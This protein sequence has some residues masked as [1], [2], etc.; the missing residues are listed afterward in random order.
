MLPALPAPPDRG[1]PALSAATGGR[2]GP[3]ADKAAGEPVSR[4]LR[5][6][7]GPYAA[8]QALVGPFWVQLTQSVAKIS[9]SCSRSRPKALIAPKTGVGQADRPTGE[10]AG[11][12][13]DSRRQNPGTRPPRGNG[14]GVRGK[15]RLASAALRRPP[16]APGR[17]PAGSCASARA[18]AGTG[19]RGS[20]SKGPTGPGICPS[21]P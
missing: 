2:L 12:E 8:V 18:L 19:R 17:H 10:T 13:I 16:A 15:G 9:I 6:G 1:G 11:A 3:K 5:P 4:P 14:Q 7:G 20:R 21:R